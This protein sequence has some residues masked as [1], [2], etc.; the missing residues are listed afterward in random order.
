MNSQSDDEI[1]LAVQRIMTMNEWIGNE[2]SSKNENK[3]ASKKGKK[4][5]TKKEP[6]FFLA[7]R[8]TNEQI[9]KAIQL[10]QEELR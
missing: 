10:V 7:I 5:K 8:I 4:R 6:N 2:D 9:L 3:K 1:L